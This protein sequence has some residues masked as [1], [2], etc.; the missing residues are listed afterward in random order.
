MTGRNYTNRLKFSIIEAG[1][2]RTLQV[3]RSSTAAK[4]D[5]HGYADIFGLN[6]FPPQQKC[7]V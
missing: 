2:N 7:N 1:E 6:S 3:Q 4:V 5:G